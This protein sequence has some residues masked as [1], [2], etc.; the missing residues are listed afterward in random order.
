MDLGP[1]SCEW[2][3]VLRAVAWGALCL[4]GCSGSGSYVWVQDLPAADPLARVRPG[5]TLSVTVQGQDSL[6]GDFPVRGD[7]TY[8]QPLVGPLRVEGLRPDE[9]EALLSK[10]LTGIV[11]DPKLS[12]TIGKTRNVTVYVLG[13]VSQPGAVEIEGTDHLLGVLARAGGLTPF[14]KKNSI[15]VIR[16]EPNRVS[17]VR[18]RYADLARG[19]V[20]SLSFTLRD[21]DAVVVE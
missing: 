9:I 19:D 7:G 4:V 2:R 3:G 5:D 13:E 21:G 17:R 8:L 18:F 10:S 11:I 16:D 1:V 20:K 14:A 12:V 6:S 15:Y